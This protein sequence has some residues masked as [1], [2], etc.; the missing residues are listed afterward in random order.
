MIGSC[1]ISP[2]NINQ[3]AVANAGHLGACK[4]DT[5]PSAMTLI[6]TRRDIFT[7]VPAALGGQPVNVR[8][9]IA[10]SEEQQMADARM[11]DIPLTP[12]NKVA[13]E[14]RGQIVLIGINRPQM[15][16]KIDPDTFYALAKAYHNFDNDPTLRA[17]VI[18]GHGEHFSRGNDVEA[19]SALAKSGKAFTLEPDQLDPLGRARKLS[20]PLLA[21]AHG[22]NWNMGHELHLAADIRVASADV[23]YRQTENAYGRVPGVA[24]VR[25]PREV[26]W[27]NA[28][29][30]LLTGDP[31]GA[32]AAYPMGVVQEV[33]PNKAAALDIAIGIANQ[34]ATCGPLGIKATLQVAHVALNATAD[35]AAYATLEK[36]YVS[37]FR[38]GDFGEGR[39][40]EAENRTPVFQRR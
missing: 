19:F 6:F 24:P 31:W 7:A 17:A 21:V 27:A 34:V 37:L 29:R 18:V 20:K 12:D 3:V 1:A 36:A 22:D 33:A 16:N 35:A 14:R 23:R 30:Y 26:G 32:E 11:I 2:F 25:W 10:H 4:T 13:V 39:R 5:S 38:S 40:A 15:F 8:P 9:N 28:M